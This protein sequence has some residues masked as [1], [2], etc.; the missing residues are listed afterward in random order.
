MSAATIKKPQLQTF[1]SKINLGQVF[2][3][4]GGYLDELNLFVAHFNSIPN[5]ISE[6]NIDCKKANNWFVEKYKA[7]IKKQY[8]IKRCYNRTEQAE[9][10]DIFYILFDDLIVDFDTNNSIARFLFSETE[11]K[12][13]ETVIGEIKK[14]KERKSRRKPHISLLVSTSRGFDINSLA[15]SKPKL[16]IE[17]NYNDDF[18]EIHKTIY[19]RLSR[20]NDKG[21]VLLHGKP[22]TGKT[23][24]IRHLISSLKKTVIFLPPNMASAITN[25]DLISILINN[26]NSIFVIEDAE[27][28]VVDREKDGTSPVSAL[29][30][31]SD[32]LLSDCLNIQVICSF[33]TDISKVDRALMRKGRLIA[34]Y[35]FKDL[36]TEKAQSLSQK[37]GFKTNLNSPMT[38]TAIYNQE[39]RDF[40]QTRKN[41][42]IGFQAIN[43]NRLAEN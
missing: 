39:E 37:L 10:D 20:K 18:K 13:V 31:I 25:P 23:S 3:A 22:G 35:E 14:F 15:I 30:N 7:E 38:L 16:S 33:N 4:K 11:I 27:N 42:P 36:E 1:A 40:Q 19:K 24:Y 9:L 21:L 26:P 34:T 2:S 28:I 8:F 43:S 6:I 41:N 32:G 12:K 5:V 17:D 29:L